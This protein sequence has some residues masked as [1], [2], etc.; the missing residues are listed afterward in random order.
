MLNFWGFDVENSVE[1]CGSIVENSVENGAV[2]DFPQGYPQSYPQ[3]F[4][5]PTQ[6]L[7]TIHC[8]E[9]GVPC[10]FGSCAP[11]EALCLRLCSH[12][13]RLTIGVVRE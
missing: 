7:F 12:R 5:Q 3:S 13:E 1:N 9:V 11:R 2:Q 10:A 4:P 6:R 8:L